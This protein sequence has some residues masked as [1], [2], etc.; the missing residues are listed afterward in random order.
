MKKISLSII[1][2]LSGFALNAQTSTKI[3]TD[4]LQRIENDKIVQDIITK[5]GIKDLEQ[6]L[7]KNWTAEKYSEFF[8]LYSLFVQEKFNE[9]KKK[10]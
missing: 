1:I 4:S 2:I 3:N 7:F 5:T 9:R 8:K 10:N 6:W